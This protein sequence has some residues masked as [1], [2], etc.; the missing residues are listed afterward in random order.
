MKTSY[1]SSFILILF[2]LILFS[3]SNSDKS[4]ECSSFLECLDGTYW[5]TDNNQSIW[6]FNDKK[7][8]AYLEVYISGYNCYSYENNFIVNAEFKY[9]TKL[10]LSEDFNGS[11]WLYSIVNDSIIEKIKA[12]GGNTTYFYKTDKSYLDELLELDECNY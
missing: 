11:N 9:Q 3:C 10:N 2:S 1:N 8:G 12:T 6:T 7:D 4:E 5:T